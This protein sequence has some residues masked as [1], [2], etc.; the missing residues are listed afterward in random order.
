MS[1]PLYIIDT[2][3]GL[4]DAHAIA[5]AVTALPPHQLVIT[6]VAGNAPLDAVTDNATWL[7]DELA[8]AVPVYRGAV[9]P[10]VGPPVDA[11]HIHG[12]DGMGGYP[13]GP[14]EVM[15]R[16][17]PAALAIVE[18]ARAR[19]GPV[20]II[21][22]G[23]LTNLALAVALEP[24]LPTMLASVTIMGGSPA[25]H[26]N[27]SLNAEYN[28]FADPYAAETV[29]ARFRDVTLLTWDASL[30]HRF[31][32]EEMAQF[33]AGDS[34]A[35]ALLRAV[36]A[37][38]LA[39]DPVYAAGADFGRPDPLAM[40]VVTHP[41]TVTSA[42]AHRIR[43]VHDG[44]LAHGVTV[45][46]ERDVLTDRAPVRIIETFDRTALLAALRV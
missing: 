29:F 4:D 44:G 36:D 31:S 23:P 3:P 37:H 38:R 9:G 21:A 39:T 25:Q 32:R 42:V 34:D 19:S 18:L 30:A 43:V 40:A 24:D 27:A 33:W 5:M 6:T 7:V 14:G 16:P 13:H 17:Q 11:V 41:E 8:P 26:G 22:L 10:L 28:I 35:A 15:P 20:H 45:V 46:D 12:R 1:E 2:D